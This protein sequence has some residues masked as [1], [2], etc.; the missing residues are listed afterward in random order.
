MGPGFRR[1]DE[2]HTNTLPDGTMV[3]IGDEAFAVKGGRFLRWSHEGYTAAIQPKRARVLTPP[4]IA[5][6]LAKGYQ[7][8]WH[9]SALGGDW[10]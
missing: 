4:L 1:D 3:A 7:P 2:K 8:R 9:E 5:A 6:I 10:A